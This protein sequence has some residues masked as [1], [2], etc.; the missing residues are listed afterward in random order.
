MMQGSGLRD[1]GRKRPQD[2]K[3]AR[4]VTAPCALS[5]ASFAV[6]IRGSGLNVQEQAT[7]NFVKRLAPFPLQHSHWLFTPFPPIPIAIGSY[8]DFPQV[9]GARGFC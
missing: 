6:K 7:Q 2:R 9:K 8:R 5:L 4:P 1:E 3:T